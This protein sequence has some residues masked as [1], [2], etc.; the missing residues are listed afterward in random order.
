MKDIYKD[1]TLDVPS[2]V[3]VSIKSR[4]VTVKGPRGV[5]T[6]NLRHLDIEIRLE[7]PRKIRFIVW[8][9]K[10]KHV[11]CIRTVRSLINNMIVG[12]TKGYQYKMR[13]VYA[14]FP[15]NVNISD[16]GREVEIRNFLGE[17]IIRKVAMPEGEDRDLQGP[18]GWALFDWE[19]FRSCLAISCFH[20]T[21]HLSQEQRYPEIFGR[22]LCIG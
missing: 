7:T 21:V 6:K 4:I 1:D 18:K 8:H 11:A 13:Y 16:N 10:R 5:L 15:I 17:K 2:N 3:E 12:V 14:H 19:R 9:G 22:Y 20:S